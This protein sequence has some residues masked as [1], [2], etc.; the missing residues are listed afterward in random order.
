MTESTDVFLYI[1]SLNVARAQEYKLEERLMEEF[2]IT[3]KD[4]GQGSL[5]RYNLAVDIIDGI[6]AGEEKAIH[7]MKEL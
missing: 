6:I 7:V 1:L 3:G 4:L 2:N 5:V